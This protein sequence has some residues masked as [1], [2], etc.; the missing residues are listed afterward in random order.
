MFFQI[1]R[2]NA[3]LLDNIHE[4]IIQ[5]QLHALNSMHETHAK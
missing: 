3:L 4:K 5:K 2:E 1:A